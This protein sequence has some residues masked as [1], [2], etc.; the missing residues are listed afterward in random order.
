MSEFRMPS[1]GADMEAGTL[2]QWLKQPGEAVHR[3]D[4]V[5]VVETQK[6]AIEIEIFEDGVLERQLV[7][8][9][10]EVPVGTPLATIGKPGEATA[11]PSPPPAQA[12]A[13]VAPPAPP[14]PPAPAPPAAVEHGPR[15]SPAARRIAEERGVD[16]R[17]LKGSGPDGAIVLADVEAAAAGAAPAAPAPAAPAPAAP[18][19]AAVAGFNFGQ[20][21]AAIAAA[22]SRSKREI[23]HYYLSDTID[24]HAAEAWV[25]RANAERPPE[26]RLLIGALFVKAVARAT[27]RL[28]EFNGFFE[29]GRFRP[30]QPVH[31]G[32]AVSIR[33]GGLVA[34]AIHDAGDLALDDLMDRMRD[35]VM[36]VRAGRFRSSEIADPTITVSSLGERGVEALYGVIYPPQV[37]IVGFGKV[38]QRPWAVEDALAVRPLV[39]ATLAADHRVSDGHRGALFLAEIGRL[40]QHPE[41]L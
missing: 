22:M 25:A 29:N 38:V 10:V 19:P 39:T 41:A 40:L 27:A 32:V 12:P 9:G 11:P 18:A 14:E 31:A 24:M 28:P 1:L 3:G 4:I 5:A 8:A 13:A 34:P 2:V 37:A 23:P 6:G 36:R 33:G 21:R 30:M 17:M 16:L 26:Q 15:A 20:M 7:G 35:L